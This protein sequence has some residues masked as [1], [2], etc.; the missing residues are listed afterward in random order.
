MSAQPLKYRRILLKLSGEALA[1][2]KGFGLHFDTMREFARQIKAIS[3]LGAQ[4]HRLHRLLDGIR[5][6]ARVVRGERRPQSD[7]EDLLATAGQ[8]A[9]RAHDEVAIGHGLSHRARAFVILAEIC[10]DGR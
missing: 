9:R 8:R 3:E 7:V 1:G 5:A 2:E 4:I 10:L 6:Y